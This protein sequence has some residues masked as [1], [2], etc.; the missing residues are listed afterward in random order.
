MDGSGSGGK[1]SSSSSSS[2]SSSGLCFC[3]FPL[4][5]SLLLLLVL[6]YRERERES[7]KEEERKGRIRFVFLQPFFTCQS[8]ARLKIGREG[9][10]GSP[11]WHVW[12][13]GAVCLF[14]W[15]ATSEL[16]AASFSCHR[17]CFFYNVDVSLFISGYITIYR[18]PEMGY[19][20]YDAWI[21]LNGRGLLWMRPFLLPAYWIY[22]LPLWSVFRPTFDKSS[23]F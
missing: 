11:D 22:S 7:L 13:S 14:W 3:L 5:S 6:L 12:G 19:I 8:M 16:S 1:K 21:C 18:C 20:T 10:V 2:S 17:F 15:W 23:P 9:R 4:V